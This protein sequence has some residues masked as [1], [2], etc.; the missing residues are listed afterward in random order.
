MRILMYTWDH[1]QVQHTE[2]G[3]QEKSNKGHDDIVVL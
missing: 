3:K 2:F 1:S